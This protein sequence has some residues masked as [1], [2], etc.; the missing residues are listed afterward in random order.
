MVM[1]LP[2]SELTAPFTWLIPDSAPPVFA[3][4]VTLPF[5]RRFT[6][7]PNDSRI[8]SAPLLR[9]FSVTLFE[10]GVLFTAALNELRSRVASSLFILIVAVLLGIFRIWLARAAASVLDR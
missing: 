10:P 9:V 2:C 6:L 7:Y 3:D 1:V 5:G 8:A 4:T